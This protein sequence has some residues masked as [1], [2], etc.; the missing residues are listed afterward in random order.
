VGD[1]ESH[2]SVVQSG[3]VTVI[4]EQLSRSRK[5]EDRAVV[6][7]EERI[8]TAVH[9]VSGTVTVETGTQGRCL[10]LS[11]VVGTRPVE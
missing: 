11:I 3:V 8:W 4:R 2:Q 1:V 5:A 10:D 6:V 9:H 7:K